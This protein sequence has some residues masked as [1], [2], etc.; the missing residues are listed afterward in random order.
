M[1]AGGLNWWQLVALLGT[2]QG[3]ML[4]VALS[5]RPSGHTP[6]RV[7]A[8]T[9]AT[10]ALFLASVVYY[11]SAL[12]GRIPHLF[13]VSQPLPFLFGPLVYLYAV[14]ASDRARRLQWRDAWHALPA[15]LVLVLSIPIFL[16]S[17]TEKLAMYD[18]IRGG[19]VPTL[20]TM[21]DPLRFLS[22]GAYTVATFVVLQRHR[23]IVADNYSSLDRV[24]LG[25]VRQLVVA[26]GGIWLLAFA[27][28]LA[29]ELHHAP[30][31]EPDLLIA[32]AITGLIYAVGYR[33]M[34]Q[35]EIVRFDAVSAGEPLVEASAP[36]IVTRQRYERSGLDAR[37]AEKIEARLVA[38]MERD[39]PYR[40]AELTLGDLAS[41]LDTSPH[42][43]SEVLNA[44]L[45]LSF[46]DFVNGYRVREVQE[47]LAG[48]DGARLTYLALALEAGFASK[49]TFNA[50]FKKQTGM[51]PSEYRSSRAT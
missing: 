11:S 15:V 39:R 24:N 23:Q 9:I 14:T 22:G 37:A 45:G 26:A 10:L 3:L 13:G 28:Q 38:T 8:A 12:V 19:N 46:Y 21:L 42:R 30:R 5:T 35:P 18:A 50:V 16:L 44:Q 33:G 32:T 4:A 41:A 6:H 51:T 31:I 40:R 48:T 20:V 36:F 49:S 27:L 43:L 7:L 34:R 29:Q 2:L 47:R 25:W 1:N 17:A